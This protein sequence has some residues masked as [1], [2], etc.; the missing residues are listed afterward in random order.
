MPGDSQRRSPRSRREI[1]SSFLSSFSIFLAPSLLFL[2]IF[3]SILFP[4]SS[5][6]FPHFGTVRGHGLA[7]NSCDILSSSHGSH[8]A[9]VGP[10]LAALRECLIFS[11]RES[12]TVQGILSHH[13]DPSLLIFFYYVFFQRLFKILRWVV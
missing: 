4:L 7:A 3:H 10:H 12:G 6:S 11:Q 1:N 9:M 5:L 2:T 13:V 8:K